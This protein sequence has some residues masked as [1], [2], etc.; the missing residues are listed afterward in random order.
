MESTSS[1]QLS[2]FV[3]E[4]TSWTGRQVRRLLREALL[5][6]RAD[7]DRVRL[8][9]ADE[10]GQ[11]QRARDEATAAALKAADD[12]WRRLW[13]RREDDISRDLLTM[14]ESVRLHVEN[15]WDNM[16]WHLDRTVDECDEEL[17]GVKAA[18]EQKVEEK[19][20]Q[21]T[22]LQEIHASVAASLEEKEE[23]M[24]QVKDFLL[25]L[26]SGLEEKEEQKLRLTRLL[27]SVS[28]QLQRE[29]LESA[30]WKRRADELGER[31]EAGARA[32]EEALRRHERLL[33]RVN[34]V[35]GLV[36]GFVGQNAR[37]MK[38]LKSDDTSDKDQ[39][40]SETNKE[41]KR[42]SEGEKDDDDDDDGE[43]ERRQKKK[44]E[45]KEKKEQEKRVKKEKKEQ[46]KKEK[47]ERK[48]RQ[49]KDR[50]S[51]WGAGIG[52]CPL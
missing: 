45:A 19:E 49:R 7:V 46:D 52:H 50:E 9:W 25:L 2:D 36:K 37:F 33:K 18:M 27:R 31:L 39:K 13:A 8:F 5:M 14:R 41:G 23:Q 40:K 35:K 38:S 32:R 1:C 26:K 16:E 48:E 11:L 17:S 29:R 24:S 3:D 6:H 44:S 20:K 10:F 51:N 43:K 21:L 12:E 22:Q 28:C 15:H 42:R 34:N 4:K 47:K 30:R